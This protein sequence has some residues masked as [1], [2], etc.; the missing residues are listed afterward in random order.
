M[1]DPRD[2][3][4]IAEG[5]AEAQET[6]VAVRLRENGTA[7]L[8]RVMNSGSA[9][10]ALVVFVIAGAFLVSGPVVRLVG[11]AA[12]IG[13]QP[14]SESAWFVQ[15]AAVSA[16]IHGGSSVRIALSASRRAEVHWSELAGVAIVS[17]GSVRVGPGRPVIVRVQLPVVRTR[18][19][20]TISVD[21]LAAPLRVEVE[22]R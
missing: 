17:S 13:E 14:Y 6:D 21:R 1:V 18:T 16:G 12:G 2:P 3:E 11:G 7:R 8:G 15:P 5:L 20:A 9:R 22:P 19:W 10:I 4:S